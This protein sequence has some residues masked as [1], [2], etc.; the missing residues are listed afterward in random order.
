M[1]R[2]I[3]VLFGLGLFACAPRLSTVYE[4]LDSYSV[5]EPSEYP[6]AYGVYLDW[7]N[8]VQIQSNALGSLTRQA[9]ER[10]VLAILNENSAQTRILTFRLDKGVELASFEANIIRPDGET[11][12]LDKTSLRDAKETLL[13]KK[14]QSESE[15]DV[16]KD[17][18]WVQK[19]FVKKLLVLP[20]LEIGTLVELKLDVEADHK[21]RVTSFGS[22]EYSSLPVLRYTEM[23]SLPHFWR[24]KATTR[25]TENDVNIS[26]RGSQRIYTWTT[27]EY[28]GSASTDFRPFRSMTT[29]FFDLYQTQF[30]LGNSVR[31]IATDWADVL[32]SKFGKLLLDGK[33]RDK[34]FKGFDA[35]IDTADCDRA[36]RVDR[37]LELARKTLSYTGTIGSIKKLKSM[38]SVV[39]AGESNAVGIGVFILK[40]LNDAGVDAKPALAN[41]F[42]Q[43]FHFGLDLPKSGVFTRPMVY[44][45]AGDGLTDPVW[46]DPTCESCERGSLPPYTYQAPAVVADSVHQGWKENKWDLQHRVTDGKLVNLS[47]NKEHIDLVTSADGTF[48]VTLKNTILGGWAQN[49]IANAKSANPTYWNRWAIGVSGARF[50]G[51]PV[52]KVEKNACDRAKARCEVSMALKY[53]GAGASEGRLIVPMTLWE[54]SRGDFFREAER[55]QDI[56]VSYPRTYSDVVTLATPD[57]YELTQHPKARTAKSALGM[58]KLTSEV[59]DGKVTVT[60]SLQ[61]NPGRY[62]KENYEAL[63]APVRAFVAARSEVIIAAKPAPPAPPVSE[64]GAEDA[65]AADAAAAEAPAAN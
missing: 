6:N 13:V 20:A 48:A 19:E 5:P 15:K 44:V 59:K 58:F 23:V 26:R 64:D 49:S 3:V 12:S 39:K 29:P 8:S 10:R 24:Y 60:R 30:V 46:I 34:L 65:P 28:A 38:K 11:I 31:N 56:Y 41:G 17:P 1:S 55:T 32:A 61:L 52:E 63:R 45:P 4:P 22:P 57:G 35:A 27:D 40:V 2:L 62:S 36:C 18:E 43:R 16:D 54:A 33:E 50:L 53:Q 14:A 9:Q 42:G 7:Q 25:H 37:T 51:A 21:K 47:G